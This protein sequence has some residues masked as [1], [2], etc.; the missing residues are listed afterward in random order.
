MCGSRAPLHP[1]LA[2]LRSIGEENHD[3][4]RWRVAP[5]LRSTLAWWGIIKECK[6]NGRPKAQPSN[7]RGW[8][9]WGFGPPWTLWLGC[10]TSLLLGYTFLSFTLQS[11]WRLLKSSGCASISNRRLR[12]TSVTSASFKRADVS[13]THSWR[14][15]LGCAAL[16]MAES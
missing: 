9:F 16:G 11:P 14:W 3:V 10:I 13:S 4:G 5:L 8:T 12:A 2:I 15:F 7:D 1:E 6:S